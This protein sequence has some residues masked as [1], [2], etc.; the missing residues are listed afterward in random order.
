MK[1][2]RGYTTMAALTK[3]QW[4]KRKKKRKRIRKIIRAV[5]FLIPIFVIGFFLFNKTR[6]N[7]EGAHKNMFSLFSPKIKIISLDTKN[8]LTI[9]KNFLTPNEYSRPE[10]PLTG[11]KSI[12]VHYTGNPGSTAAGNRNYFEN[13][14]TKQTTSA[15]SHYVVGLE[16]EVI[17]CVPLNEVAYASNNRNEDSISIETCHPDKEGKFN[18]KTYE[19]LVALTALLCEEFDLD[20]EDIIRHY[21]VTGKKCPLYYVEHP[22]EWEAFKDDVMAYIEQNKEQ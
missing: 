22:E 17:Q 21:D 7:A 5:L 9:E 18:K 4:I 3:E 20:R 2:E 10:T 8:L 1:K 16:G 15:S 12:V 14:K 19:S 11:V 6:D 13:L